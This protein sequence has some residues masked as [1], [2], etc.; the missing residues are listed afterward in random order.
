MFKDHTQLDTS[1]R[2]DSSKWVISSSRSPVWTTHNKH[3]GR[4]TTSPVRFEPA[5]PAIERPKT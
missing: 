4:A 3:K 1:S 5:I 2:Q